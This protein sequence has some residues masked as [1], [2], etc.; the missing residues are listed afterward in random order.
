MTTRRLQYAF[1]YRERLFITTHENNLLKIYFLLLSALIFS[2]P[3]EF[4]KLDDKKM[5]SI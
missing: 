5:N 1:T 3:I 2:V 4:H